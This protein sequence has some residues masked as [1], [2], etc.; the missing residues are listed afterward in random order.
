[1][2]LRLPLTLA[3]SLLAL[4]LGCGSSDLHVAGAPPAS[5]YVES[6]AQK[7]AAVSLGQMRLRPD[8]CASI[9]ARPVYRPLEAEDF[10]R[11]LKSQNLE[12]RVVRAR[13]DLVFADVS[14]A[15]TARTV[16]FR[17]AVL[18]TAGAAGRELHEA[19]LE[20]GEGA[21][22]VRRANL[23]VLG[24]NAPLDDVVVL[25]VRT[26]L[27]CWGVLMVAGHDDTYVIPGGYSEL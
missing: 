23:A 10:V 9:D 6:F 7:P 21:W 14:T 16:R 2:S 3:S 12:A 20:H 26:K 1:M 22:G 4:C 13:S 11:F 5:T 8:T 19:L 18:G 15:G 25:S 24:P 17:V 27:A